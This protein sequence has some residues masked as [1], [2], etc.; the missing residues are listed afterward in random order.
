MQHQEHDA[1]ID[2]VRYWKRALREYLAIVHPYRKRM[3]SIVLWVL[4]IQ[5]L[6]IVEPSVIM[7][8]VNEVGR[9]GAASVKALPVLGV[10]AGAALFVLAVLKVKQF[11]GARNVEAD[12]EVDL[13][14]ACLRKLLE[15]PMSYHQGE[16]TGRIVGKIVRGVNRIVD[17]TWNVTFEFVPMV[18]MAL[19]T[20]VILAVVNPWYALLTLLVCTVWVTILITA[21]NSQ[22]HHYLR[23]HAL[24]EEA[25][26]QLGE[27]VMNML[28]VQAFAQEDRMLERFEGMRRDIRKIID[29]EFTKYD[30]FAMGRSHVVNMARVGILLATA[31]GAARG[32][33]SLGQVV[34]L[35]MLVERFFSNIHHLAGVYDRFMECLDPLHRVTVLLATPNTVP[36][37]TDPVAL[38]ETVAGRIELRGVTYRYKR[39]EEDG[40]ATA[41]E[42]RAP[43]LRELSFVA[44]PGQTIGIAG[45]SGVGK[46]TFVS[47]VL[48]ADDPDKGE[49][50]LDGTDLRQIAKKDLRARIG[51]VPQNVQIFDTSV[52]DNIRFGKPSATDAEVE[53]AARIAGAHD[54]IKDL[55]AG[56]ETRVGTNGLTLSGGQRQRLG[57]ARAVLAKP[58]VLI[59]DEATSSVDPV[60]IKKIMA[61]LKALR[62]RCT[63]LLISHQIAT[64]V[65]LADRIVVLDQGGVAEEGTHAE[66]MR[67]EGG[68]YRRLAAVQLAMEVAQ[69]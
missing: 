15:L 42:E 33:Y 34:F 10:F 55:P 35:A 45:H 26:E 7:S 21:R 23:R 56:Y 9:H 28:T 64:L 68:R 43:T 58:E 2:Q 50:L 39:L 40:V 17:L 37:P 30:L 22:R 38:P 32:G 66:L 25:D 69:A 4:I 27:V 48:R 51:Y 52:A 59:F 65:E 14:V 63:I 47:M 31:Y 8:I 67:H 44:E 29:L 11:A 5:V 62:G 16:S 18:I 54:F 1:Q 49:V 13:P 60:S 57:I 61:A 36:E 19:V 46:S 20:L 41:T 6:T 3:L 53:T 12:L 24:Y